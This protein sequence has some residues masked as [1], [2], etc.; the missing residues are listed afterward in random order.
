MP[1]LFKA[2]SYV[3]YFW[4]SDGSEP[5]HIHVAKGK[6]SANGTKFWITSSGGC[7][8]AHNRSKIFVSKLNE[9]MDLISAQFFFVC[10]NYGKNILKLKKSIFIANS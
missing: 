6:P 7:V 9:F 5:I 10:A 4:T 3:F 1:S 8:L 2:S